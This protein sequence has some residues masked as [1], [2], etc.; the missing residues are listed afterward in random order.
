MRYESVPNH[1]YGP[2]VVWGGTLVDNCPSVESAERLA[3]AF[4][5][6]QEWDGRYATPTA[7]FNLTPEEAQRVIRHLARRVRG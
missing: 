3:A 4:N 1:I 5:E 7:I 2:A 6:V